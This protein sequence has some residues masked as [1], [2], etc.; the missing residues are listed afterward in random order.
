MERSLPPIHVIGDGLAGSETAWQV[1][2]AG[3]PVVLHEMRPA[4]GT[5]AHRTKSLAEF[6]CSNLFRADDPDASAVDILHP[7]MR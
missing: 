5:P 6:V 3:I 1:A 7:E 2:R 4:R